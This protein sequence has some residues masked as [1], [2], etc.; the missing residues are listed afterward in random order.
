MFIPAAVCGMP[1]R[2]RAEAGA[3]KVVQ[4]RGGGQAR[5]VMHRK[6]D[7]SLEG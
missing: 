3:E 1:C 5:V 6:D 4:V 2:V 7:G